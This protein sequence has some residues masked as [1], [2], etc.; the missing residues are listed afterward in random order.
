MPHT[1]APQS[2]NVQLSADAMTVRISIPADTDPMSVTADACLDQLR[3]EMIQVDQRIEQ[4]VRRFI[5][6]HNQA[7]HL[8]SEVALEGR[9]AVAGENGYFQWAEG[10]DPAHC[11][12]QAAD[13]EH[14]VDYYEHS[15]FVTVRTGQLIGRVVPPAPGTHGTNL[16]GETIAPR[17][18]KVCGTKPDPHTIAVATDGECRALI[19][20]VIHSKGNKISV[21]PQLNVPSYVDFE[22]GNIRF[23]GNVTIAKGV[24][25]RF[26]VEASGSVSIA[27]LVEA[28]IIESGSD[29]HMPGGMAAKGA[30]KITVGQ[31]LYAKYMDNVKG[32]VKRDAV[33]EREVIQCNLG[34][35]RRL[36]VEKG[37]LIGGVTRVGGPA[38]LAEL[39]SR[40]HLKTRLV[41]ATIPEL[42]QMMALLDEHIAELRKKISE[43]DLELT[44]LCSRPRLDGEQ[45]NRMT[46]LM[47]Y[48]PQLETRLAEAEERSRQMRQ[49]FEQS[50]TVDLQVER[51]IHAGS[52]IQV[53][54]RTIIFDD[55]IHKPVRMVWTR[56]RQLVMA[57]GEGTL[58]QVERSPFVKVSVND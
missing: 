48:G 19:D 18:G 28:A 20:G 16:R 8:P 57:V 13:N 54:D 50:R 27:Q 56:Q 7:P 33:I 44:Q 11:G 51:A 39:G 34:I 5:E 58:H 15:P 32:L 45:Q 41:L 55:S 4:E 24:R 22:T 25:D 37:A 47:E 29:L 6:A 9:P 30:G 43:L 42:E 35:N 1:A 52:T 14:R 23:T 2:I 10:C 38:Q 46:K 40:A 17:D 31:D 21:N 3:G 36:V 12:T 53:D 49:R 26:H